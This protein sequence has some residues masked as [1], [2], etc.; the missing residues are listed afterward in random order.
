V[1]D[2]S[3]L[4]YSCQTNKFTDFSVVTMLTSQVH[5]HLV[6]EL[7]NARLLVG[8]G[9]FVVRRSII[10]YVK[11]FELFHFTANGN[12]NENSSLSIRRP[13]HRSISKSGR[14]VS[15]T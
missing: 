15:S 7:T 4:N 12:G 5:S 3:S 1:N 13:R 9:D 14:N 11:V 6:L 2:T 8:F 10:E